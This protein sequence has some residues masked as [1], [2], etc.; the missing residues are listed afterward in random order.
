M[1]LD[2]EAALDNPGTVFEAAL[3]GEMTDE[4]LPEDC[5]FATPVKTELRYTLS[6]DGLFIW[7]KM[8]VSIKTACARCLSDIIYPLEAE[9]QEVCKA[10]PQT[11]DAYLYKGTVVEL[12]KLLA[13]QIS[14]KLPVRFLCREDCKGLC[15][16]CG[17]NRNHGDCGCKNEQEKESPFSGLKGLFDQ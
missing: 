17:A 2:I 9:F 13:D 14:L 6:E 7:G 12:D 11:E 16:V 5:S 3:A 8:W 15:P 1:R 4:E 10:D